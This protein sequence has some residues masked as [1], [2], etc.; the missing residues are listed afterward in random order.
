MNSDAFSFGQE[1]D[2]VPLEPPV[3]ALGYGRYLKGKAIPQSDAKALEYLRKAAD[4]ASLRNETHSLVDLG[5]LFG[6]VALSG[7]QESDTL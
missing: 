2:F 7:R 3:K 5:E 4:Q 6:I 1:N